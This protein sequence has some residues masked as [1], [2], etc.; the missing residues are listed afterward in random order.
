[1]RTEQTTYTRHEAEV[2]E[3]T[4]YDTARSNKIEALKEIIKDLPHAEPVLVFTHSAR[5]IPA[6]VHQLNKAKIPAVEWSGRTSTE[7]RQRIKQSFGTRG[8]AQVIVA[9]LGAIGEGVDGLQ[10][11]WST[12]VWLS[13][14]DDNMLNMQAKGRVHRLGQEEV[15]K[16]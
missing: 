8:G 11:V 1:M 4:I 5:F 2:D 7:E 16:R 14:H 13:P 3:V 10:R 6:V 9:G 15:V 12:E